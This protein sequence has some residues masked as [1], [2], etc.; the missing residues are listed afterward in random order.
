MLF[1]KE[2]C[3]SSAARVKRM[4]ALV[5]LKLPANET[6]VEEI[7]APFGGAIIRGLIRENG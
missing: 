3:A 5:L 1:G 6:L 7:G 4:G 2:V